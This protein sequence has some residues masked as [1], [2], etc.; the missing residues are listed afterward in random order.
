MNTVSMTWVTTGALRALAGRPIFESGLLQTLLCLLYSCKH[1]ESMSPDGGHPQLLDL[2]KLR[3]HGLSL[4]D[5]ERSNKAI[6]SQGLCGLV[7]P[8]L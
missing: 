7:A 3:Q 5:C 4:L 6:Y 1:H 2:A 8:G